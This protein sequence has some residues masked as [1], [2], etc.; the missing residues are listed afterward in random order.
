VRARSARGWILTCIAALAVGAAWVR[1]AQ[2]APPAPTPPPAAV[3]PAEAPAADTAPAAPTGPSPHI[4][5]EKTELDLGDVIHG[6]DAVATFT[7]KNTGP[8]PLHI[9]AA[10]PG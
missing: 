1:P 6:Q 9:L 10:K 2:S 8:V 7:Y 5:F 3:V 4:Q